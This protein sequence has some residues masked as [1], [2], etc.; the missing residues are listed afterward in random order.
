MWLRLRAFP[1]QEVDLSCLTRSHPTRTLVVD[2]APC[3]EI[4]E[5]QGHSSRRTGSVSCGE[6]G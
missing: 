3:L 1:L 5:A 4:E 2:T 6:I